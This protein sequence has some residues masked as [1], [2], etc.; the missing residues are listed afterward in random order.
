MTD[1]YT[2]NTLAERWGC[3][4]RHVRELINSGRLQAIKLGPK[5][6][7]IRKEW[8]EE[9]E[10]RSMTDRIRSS[11]TE[12]FSPSSIVTNRAAATVTL[13]GPLTRL[14]LEKLRRQS[15]T[16]STDPATSE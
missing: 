16:P 5:I 3:T 15:G 2:P 8:V 1:V 12:V 6:I 4:G 11:D 9:F 13:S 10:C 14:K 7:R